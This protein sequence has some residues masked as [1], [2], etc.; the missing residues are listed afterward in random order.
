MKI[1]FEDVSAR[2][3]SEAIKLA[4]DDQELTFRYIPYDISPDF[5]NKA[6]GILRVEDCEGS[7]WE[8]GVVQI[9]NGHFSKYRIEMDNSRE[10]TM[11]S[12][13]AAALADQGGL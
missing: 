9:Q 4:N 2:Q 10:R 6:G 8:V 5:R 1:I 13:L 11:I 7:G 3:I 12:R